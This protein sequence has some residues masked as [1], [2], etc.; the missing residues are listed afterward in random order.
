MKIHST[1]AAAVVLLG[2]A[3]IAS[4]QNSTSTA[5]AAKLTSALQSRQLGVIAARNPDQPGG[6]VAAFYLPGSQLLV[7]SGPS[8]V[9]SALDKHI[10]AGKHMDVYMALND[11]RDNT[12]RFFVMDLKADGLRPQ[13]EKDEPFD[14]IAREGVTVAFDGNWQAQRLSEAAYLARFAEDD[15][16]YAR[17][18]QVLFASLQTAP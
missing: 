7:V 4:A 8:S 11:A 6:F 17:L 13:C 14:S 16:R 3:A 1:V 9:P 12:G 2:G 10:A 15:A 5:A 18:L